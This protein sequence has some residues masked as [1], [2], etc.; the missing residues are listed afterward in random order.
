MDE[1]S[2]NK[3]PITD[4]IFETNADSDESRNTG[5][6]RNNNKILN[7]CDQ[8]LILIKKIKKVFYFFKHFFIFLIICFII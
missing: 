7:D 8:M 3:K 1:E 2:P 5:K 4:N 6:V